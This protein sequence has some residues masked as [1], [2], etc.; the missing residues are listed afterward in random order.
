M[1]TSVLL[2]PLALLVD[3]V[4][5]FTAPLA[6]QQHLYSHH[7]QLRAASDPFRPAKAS[8]D[9]LVINALQRVLFKD[10]PAD[11]AVSALLQSRDDALT[12][13]EDAL[14]RSRVHG[15]VHSAQELRFTLASAVSRH[16]FIAKYGMQGDYG[17]SEDLE[18]NPLAQLNHA[19]CLLALYMLH[20]EGRGE[21]PAFVDAEKLDVLRG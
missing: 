17:V 21:E 7:L 14:V 5:A 4:R 6:R 3:H 2:L 18:S 8:I 16:A 15:V 10:E 11:A 9:P 13:E 12:P 20:R 1:H 19:E